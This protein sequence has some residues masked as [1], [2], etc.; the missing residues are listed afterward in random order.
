MCVCVCVC[1]CVCVSLQNGTVHVG[2]ATNIPELFRHSAVIKLNCSVRVCL[3]RGRVRVTGRKLKKQL[4]IKGRTRLTAHLSHW[5][6]CVCVCVYVCVCVCVCVCYVH[7][8]THTYTHTRTHTYTHI[9]T[10]QGVDLNCLYC[11]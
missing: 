8:L 9:H 10:Q 11:I 1:L 4:N 7:T 5:T 2:R 6:V 3:G